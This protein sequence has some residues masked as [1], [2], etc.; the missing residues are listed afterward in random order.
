M[1]WIKFPFDQL[2]QKICTIFCGLKQILVFK[3][4]AL[5]LNLFSHHR[6]HLYY[7]IALTK[8]TTNKHHIQQPTK[9]L[10]HALNNWPP[11]TCFWT[12]GRTS[13]PIYCTPS[14]Y[15][16]H[17]KRKGWRSSN[18]WRFMRTVNF[19]SSASNTFVS[20]W[21]MLWR[22]TKLTS[23]QNSHTFV[24]INCNASPSS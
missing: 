20:G 16:T 4:W 1:K 3:F 19:V 10:F 2:S 24:M 8:T 22:T 18:V 9:M 7:N 21:P 14:S 17:W 13:K 12:L 15:H 11:T 23:S 5:Y 6:R